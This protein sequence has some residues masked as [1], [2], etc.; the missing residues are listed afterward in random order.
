VI[1][2]DLVGEDA[3]QKA[4]EFAEVFMD[5][6]KIQDDAE[7]HMPFIFH[8]GECLE[9]ENDNLFD[10]I[11]MKSPRIGHGINLTKHSDMFV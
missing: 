10:L 4:Q 2:F 3:S 11:L 1:G 8:G 5:H 7:H 9:F 6:L